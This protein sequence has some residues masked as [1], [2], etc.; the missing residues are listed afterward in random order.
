[1]R[2][3]FEALAFPLLFWTGSDNCFSYAKESE[4][5]K[6]HH[7]LMRYCQQRLLCDQLL[8]PCGLLGSEWILAQYSRMIDD[9]LSY[10]TIRQIRVKKESQPDD[11]EKLYSPNDFI[12]A[13]VRKEFPTFFVTFTCNPHWPEITALV[14]AYGFDCNP[15]NWKEHASL[16]GR[17]FEKSLSDIIDYIKNS[18]VL[19]TVS[20]GVLKREY[21]TATG[22]PHAH[23]LFWSSLG[24][25]FK[26]D[27][28]KISDYVTCRRSGNPKVAEQ[29]FLH[30]THSHLSR[31]GPKEKYHRGRMVQ[32]KRIKGTDDNCHYKYQWAPQEFNTL[33]MFGRVDYARGKGDEFSLPTNLDLLMKWQ[34][35]VYVVV[36]SHN[37]I[38]SYTFDYNLKDEHE[39]GHDEV[40]LTNKTNEIKKY[41]ETWYTSPSVITL[42]YHEQGAPFVCPITQKSAEA[43]YIR[44][45]DVLI[46][47]EATMA[48]KQLEVVEN[49]LPFES[50]S[51]L[52]AGDFLQLP[53]VVRSARNV[54]SVVKSW[55]GM[56]VMVLEKNMRQS[57]ED[58]F[59]NLLSE[60]SKG[61]NPGDDN[62][63]RIPTT[64]DRKRHSNKLLSSDRNQSDI[65]DHKKY[66]DEYMNS[67][68]EPAK[69]P[70]SSEVKLNTPVIVLRNIRF[71]RVANCNR[72]Y[73]QFVAPKQRY[74]SITLKNDR[75]ILLPRI[76][77][78][79]TPPNE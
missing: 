12:K 51:I 16:V 38:F 19:G 53:C 40:I 1:M 21:Q 58:S 79:I 60:I 72:G 27:I 67:V 52:F 11:Q 35:Y 44:K 63:L 75:T 9:R 76:D 71:A 59:F 62:I 65:P 30:M 29:Q 66:T 56:R 69:Q 55:P 54:A 2:P 4:V 50:V 32:S 74:V 6:A 43:E 48:T 49:K 13:D 42:P 39:E 70:Q 46:M 26:N 47:D 23:V 73:V 28:Q 61:D 45:L 3:E 34:G 33:D 31:C 41:L 20:D 8:Q 64:T 17:I 18:N 25:V 24:I 78:E 7:T 10:Q 68:W 5:E 57:E 22:L 15:V 77:F 37:N 36:T 14:R